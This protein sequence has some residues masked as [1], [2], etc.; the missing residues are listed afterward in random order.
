[1]ETT[2]ENST[3]FE[4]AITEPS[5]VFSKPHDVIYCDFLTHEQ[6]LTSLKNW[7]STLNHLSESTSEGMQGPPKNDDVLAEIHSALEELEGS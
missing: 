5:I 6:K 1:M 7:E 2:Q 4:K 3:K